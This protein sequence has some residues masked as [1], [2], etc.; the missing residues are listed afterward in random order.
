MMRHGTFPF[1]LLHRLQS[2]PGLVRRDELLA[3]GDAIGDADKAMR[4]L[5][6]EGFVDKVARGIWLIPSGKRPRQE[7]PRFWSNPEI[8]DK[9]VIIEATLMNPTFRDL[10]GLALAYGLSSVEKTMAELSVNKVLHSETQG[11]LARML[12]NIRRGFALAGE[13]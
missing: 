9:Q 10:V 5:A 1:R 6:S 8:D 12:A 4:R 7:T 2:Q 11:R 13:G 3:I